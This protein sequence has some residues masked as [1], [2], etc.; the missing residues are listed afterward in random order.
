MNY[1]I[2]DLHLQHKNIVKH[3]T[4]DAERRDGFYPFADIASRDAMIL[5]N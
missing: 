3:E 4:D 1:Y 2:S 5:K